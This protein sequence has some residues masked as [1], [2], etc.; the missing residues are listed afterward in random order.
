MTKIHIAYCRRCDT[1][2]FEIEGNTQNP[3]IELPKWEVVGFRLGGKSP[4]HIERF[5]IICCFSMSNQPAT[6]LRE[7]AT[8][9]YT[10]NETTGKATQKFRDLFRSNLALKNHK[11]KTKNF[12]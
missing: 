2:L 5:Q 11:C 12:S 9:I 1:N 10:G 3:S 4:M 6:P 8:G 7:N